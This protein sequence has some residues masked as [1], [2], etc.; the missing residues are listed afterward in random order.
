MYRFGRITFVV[1]EVCLSPS[2]VDLMEQIKQSEASAIVN[3]LTQASHASQ[4]II[5]LNNATDS[6][7]Q[8]RKQLIIQ[9]PKLK[10]SKPGRNTVPQTLD[11]ERVCRICLETEATQQNPLCTPC[12]CKGGSKYIHLECV[13]LWLD[14]K[15][16]MFRTNGVRSFYWD[17]LQCEVCKAFF[18]LKMWVDGQL[19]DLLKIELPSSGQYIVLE[20]SM[21]SSQIK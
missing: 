1:R 19:I 20:S 4:F 15:K 2:Q 17:D 18:L 10:N 9:N 13:K 6:F 21:A 5:S 3:N 12:N 8:N 14:S 16:L 7:K 11:E